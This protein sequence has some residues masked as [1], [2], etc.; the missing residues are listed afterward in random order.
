MW[1][2]ILLVVILALLL[3][4]LVGCGKTNQSNS[5]RNESVTVTHYDYPT[6]V[7]IKGVI[8]EA[9]IIVIG[10]YAQYDS[11]WNMARNPDDITNE[12]PNMYVEGKLYR[13]TVDKYLKGNGSSSILVNKKFK[14]KDGQI[15]ERYVEPIFD[16]TVVLFLKYEKDFKNYYGAIQPF[17]FKLND[18][19][20][21][22]IT[23]LRYIR[24]S[25]TNEIPLSEVLTILTQ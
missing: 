20:L 11:S 8:N 22:V 23:N 12:D 2:T 10:K 9:E 14:N 15:D 6:A 18:N 24:Q 25:F 4:S 16:E 17:E 21:Q 13:F 19:Q 3:S 7:N 5:N 1:K